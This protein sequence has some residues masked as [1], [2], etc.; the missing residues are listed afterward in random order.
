MYQNQIYEIFNQGFIQEQFRQEQLKRYHND[1]MWKSFKCANKLDEFLKSID[2]VAPEYQ[3]VAFE[4][5]C[6][7]IGNHFK[8]RGI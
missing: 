4:Q 1:Q 8:Q 5:C 7:I 2:E 6:F 3:Q